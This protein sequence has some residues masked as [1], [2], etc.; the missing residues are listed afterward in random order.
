MIRKISYICL[1]AVLTLLAVSCRDTGESSFKD[2]V[3]AQKLKRNFP[4]SE[5]VKIEIFSYK[6]TY[7]TDNPFSAILNDH[8]NNPSALKDVLKSN[9]LNIKER[10]VLTDKQ[11]QDLAQLLYQESCGDEIKGN[12]FTPRHAILFYDKEDTPI[13]LTEIS[14]ECATASFSKEFTKYELC[15]SKVHKLTAFFKSI[16]INYFEEPVL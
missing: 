13:A 6:S 4:F 1:L 15:E 9:K 5:A 12:C 8:I 14:L 3:D 2:K 16:G 10:V 11:V 7:E